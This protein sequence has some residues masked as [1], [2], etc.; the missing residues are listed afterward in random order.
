M[1]APS[2][3]N[4]MACV[5]IIMAFL[6]PWCAPLSVE[7]SDTSSEK[8]PVYGYEVVNVFPHDPAAFT[9]G[10]IFENGYIYESTG[11]YGQSTVR[12]V[13]IETGEVLQVRRLDDTYFGEGIT[14]LGDRLI[15]LTYRETK[16]FVYDKETFQVLKEFSYHGEGWGI[17]HDGRRLIM[18]DGTDTLRVLDATTFRETGVIRVHEGHTP[19]TRLNEL[20]YVKGD[21]YANVWGT[22][23]IAIISPETGSVKG[24]L[25][26]GGLRARLSTTRR[27]LSTIDALNG[28]A[29]D[30][31]GDR[32]FV[33]GK[34]WPS[35]FEIRLSAKQ[36]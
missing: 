9:Q 15:Q 4:V 25:D 6:L 35:I 23:R 30:K 27:Y 18:S 1:P 34:Y 31:T 17:T 5:A 22:D 12:K 36:Q 8:S 7:P 26:L 21:I 32:L 28:I 10:L 29:Y 33:T 14:L 2:H 19:V 13:K 3:C 20:E 11:L 24:W 16:G